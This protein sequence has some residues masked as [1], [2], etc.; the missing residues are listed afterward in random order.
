[1]AKHVNHLLNFSTGLGGMDDNTRRLLAAA[2]V[3]KQW[4]APTSAVRVCVLNAAPV[5]S[6]NVPGSVASG[7]VLTPEVARTVR[8]RMVAIGT[9]TLTVLNPDA[10]LCA[11]LALPTPPRWPCLPDCLLEDVARGG[12]VFFV[13][14]SCPSVVVR[15][16]LPCPCVPCPSAAGLAYH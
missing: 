1:M 4:T 6:L 9:V 11:L 5:I 8:C 3:A 13:L 16:A 15:P 2:Y 7:T 10:L 14:P 12:P